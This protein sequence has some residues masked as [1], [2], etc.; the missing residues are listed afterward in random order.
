MSVNEHKSH[1]YKLKIGVITVSS[2]RTE[3]TDE[4]GKLLKDEIVKR[5][6]EL[7]HYAVVKD[8][9]LEILNAL[10]NAL[11]VCDAVI[12][13]GGTGISKYDITADSIES[14]LDK[15]LPGF[16]EIFRLRSY[17]EIGTAAML[18]RAVA[19]VCCDKLVF[20]VPGSKNA[21][22]SAAEL[23]FEEIEHMWYEIHKEKIKNH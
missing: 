21:V 4:S 9:K 6:H 12:L 2:T 18:S 14:V 22:K 7:C 20:A 23:I 16:G 11:M 5:G 1:R 8:S 13:S 3:R 19:G 15:S 10:F 17:D